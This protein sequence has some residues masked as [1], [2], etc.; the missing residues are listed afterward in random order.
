MKQAMKAER[1][2]ERDIKLEYV[3]TWGDAGSSSNYYVAPYATIEQ[4]C[5]LV[6]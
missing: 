5:G 4:A 1:E 3:G 2:R 6:S